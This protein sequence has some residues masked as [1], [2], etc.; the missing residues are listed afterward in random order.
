MQFFYKDNNELDFS[1][2]GFG[3]QKVFTEAEAV[4]HQILLLLFLRPGDY[5]SLPEMGINISKQVRYK[6]LDFL[7]GNELREFIVKQIREYLTHIDLDD[8]NIWSAKYK[9][10]YFIV[11][12]FKLRAEKTISVALKRRSS[13][14]LIDVSV[15]FN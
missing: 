11:L 10:E 1:L 5:P 2:N 13:S 4:Y 3:Q 6:N 8:L 12:D 7:V 15:E 9:G 14:K